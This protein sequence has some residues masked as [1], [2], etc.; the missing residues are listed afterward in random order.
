MN[1]RILSI[2]ILSL[3]MLPVV[4]LARDYG[5]NSTAAA[6]GIQSYGGS[7]TATIGRVV[8]ALLSLIG[9]VFFVLVV[10][11][12]LMWM[13]AQGNQD[14]V[15]RAINTIISAAIGLIVVLAA[16][17]IT[18]FVLDAV[19]G[20]PGAPATIADP[21]ASEEPEGVCVNS[22]GEEADTLSFCFSADDCIDEAFP[23][24]NTTA[25]E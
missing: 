5:L 16:Y 15:K 6:A 1:K 11:G 24:C 22:D 17:A 14:M 8:G 19:Q 3:L 4:V 9:I 13:T 20:T 25:A 2:A 23:I 12:G 21:E 18:S 7:L 10:Y